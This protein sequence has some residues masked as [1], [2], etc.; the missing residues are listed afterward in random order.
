[1][2]QCTKFF[3]QYRDCYEKFKTSLLGGG[4]V[5]LLQQDDYD[6]RAKL[7]SNFD[8]V[9]GK[10]SGGKLLFKISENFL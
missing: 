2:P 7:S 8:L 4:G 9:R 6:M 3:Y 10:A 5:R 1:M